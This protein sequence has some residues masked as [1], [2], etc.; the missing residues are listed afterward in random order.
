M[1]VSP[2]V[3]ASF[4]RKGA[5]DALVFLGS[6]DGAPIEEAD[7][8]DLDAVFL[9]DESAGYV[10]SVKEWA[11]AKGVR[12]PSAHFRYF[13]TLGI[14][15]G[16][17]DQKG[18]RRLGRTMAVQH[19]TSELAA[20]LIR[21][22]DRRQIASPSQPVTWGLQRMQV[23]A[24]WQ[25]GLT[26]KGVVVGHLDTGVDADHETLK[27][28]VSAFGFIDEG[29]ELDPYQTVPFDSDDHGTHTA[30][31]IA[32]RASGGKAIG[33]APGA[34]LAC[35]AV[36]EGGIVTARLLSGLEFVIK[37][38]ARVV[39]VSLG[40]RGYVEEFQSLAAR[41]RQAG[42]L[43]VFAVG[44]EGANTSRCPGNFDEALSVG[45]ADVAGSVPSFSSSEEVETGRFVPDLVAPGTGIESAMPGGGY[46]SMSGSS[47]AAPHVSGLAALL[48]EAKPDATVDELEAAI[49]KS[50]SLSAG[51]TRARAGLGFPS[52]PDALRLLV[53]F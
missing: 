33:T 34:S 19:V 20:S 13:P 6:L 8:G 25:R 50:C 31:T 18:L 37:H 1:R 5:A 51:I 49:F 22:A 11:A 4:K 52:A 23:D 29:G 12:A 45:A 17:V 24:L 53:G 47:M 43:P 28:A 35:A 36:I 46:M 40:V 10:S 30:G 44:N 26:G 32:G 14:A 3:A 42:V 21:P 15:M 41:L 38:G 16:T 2:S 9:R 27:G 48:L 7:P 39:N